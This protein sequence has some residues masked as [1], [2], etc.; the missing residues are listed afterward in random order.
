MKA[1]KVAQSTARRIFRLCSKNGK[2][3][4]RKMKSV[5]K[6]IGEEKPR[7]YR[8]ILLSL[9]RLVQAEVIKKQVTVESAVK[10]DETTLGK[11]QTSLRDEYG[12][13]LTFKFAV[14]A[15]LLGGLRIRVGNDVYDGSV[16]ARLET[17]ANSF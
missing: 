12:E 6:R 7:D 2:M 8:G 15:E 14:N 1:S 17:L 5:I 4:A 9:R 13:G 3:N 11:V 16:K 10:L